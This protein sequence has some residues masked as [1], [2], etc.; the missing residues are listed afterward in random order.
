MNTD[1]SSE[2]GTT[3]MPSDMNFT[4]GPAY[5]STPNETKEVGGTTIFTA[6]TTGNVVTRDRLDDINPSLWNALEQP[7]AQ[8]IKD[9]LSKPTLLA[10]G[11]FATTDTGNFQVVNLPE[12]FF[13]NPRIANK[14][15]GVAMMR[16][17]I[18]LTLQVNAVR[19][20]QGRY[21]LAFVPTGGLVNSNS[22]AQ[23]FYRAHAANMT[24]VSQLP[25]VEIDLATQ[26]VAE[27]RIPYSSIFPYLKVSA[28]TNLNSLGIAFLRPYS[29]L[30]AGSGDTT[31][32]Y[33]L[34]GRLENVVLSGNVMPQSGRR[35]GF[36]ATKAKS[37]TRVEQE[38]KSEGPV[39]SVLNTISQGT[40]V[41]S[42]LPILG[43]ILGQVSWASG[44]LGGAAAAFGF[45]KPTL[46]DKPLR[47]NKISYP[48][49]G[50]ADG[51]TT[52][53]PLALKTDNEV[54]IHSGVGRTD[55]D[56]M[57]ID[58]IKQ[59]YAYSQ[60]ITWA[61]SD[62]S[63]AILATLPHNP[64]KYYTSLGVNGVVMTPVCFLANNFRVWRGGM[65]FRFKIVKTEF[66][67]GRLIFAYAPNMGLATAPPTV[68]TSTFLVR[69]IVDIRDTT[70]VEICVPYVVPELYT[71]AYYNSGAPAVNSAGT[72]YIM[73]GDP[74]VAPSSV[75][76][77]VHLLVEV[78]GAPDFEVAIPAGNN[79]TAV[80]PFATQCGA[81]KDVVVSDTCL[82]ESQSSYL[83]H[84]C[85]EF[86]MDS[87]D[88][89]AS[90][91]AIGER[92]ESF[93]Q[94]IKRATPLLPSSGTYPSGTAGQS[95]TFN[96]YALNPAFETGSIGGTLVED[97]FRC[98]FINTLSLC[99]VYNN[100]GMRLYLP[101]AG[102][103]TSTYVSVTV[104]RDPSKYQ[105]GT[106]ALYQSYTPTRV[107]PTQLYTNNDDAPHVS[108][109][110]YS[111]TIGRTSAAQIVTAVSL[112][113]TPPS[114]SVGQNTT[115]VS[116][117]PVNPSLVL[118][119]RPY[120]YC[121]DDYSM[122]YWI[123]TVPVVFN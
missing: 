39:S 72:F 78:C 3:Q 85:V 16:A 34:F 118:S 103:Y 120:K 1:S 65:K 53:M 37:V 110:A 50:T 42:R 7:G 69:E 68:D 74:L 57:S 10:S 67:S 13:S 14:L 81:L 122:S 21:V 51:M 47:M 56:E 6:D 54:L 60:T 113:S 101:T 114:D 8:D 70:E 87:S 105:L 18:V 35:V 80:I 29:P 95:F 77:S 100:G 99:Y 107:A 89:Q 75:T 2:R 41:L 58:F 46:L 73:V 44:I 66:H 106:S 11:N 20:Q 43:P 25:H 48:Y 12:A 63:G 28:S 83:K 62:V 52:A 92:A 55:I 88:L 19:F 115:A 97:T 49:M 24:S 22:G 116:V 123:G 71:T 31:C 36:K 38:S 33:M 40:A 90:V 91:V 82:F 117:T 64:L 30:E 26:T 109:P 32:G 59:Q 79:M 86:G 112:Y 15:Y 94:L 104:D 23:A 27:L 102:N 45:S 76:A 108:V 121:A 119:Y 17:D 4:S 9:F 96:A 84:D 5:S 111:R 93:R 61:S 98:D